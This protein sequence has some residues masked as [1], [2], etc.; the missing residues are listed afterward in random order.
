MGEAARK[1]AKLFSADAI[2]PEFEAAYGLA[3]EARLKARGPRR[4]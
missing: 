4:R 3:D 1:R 2:V